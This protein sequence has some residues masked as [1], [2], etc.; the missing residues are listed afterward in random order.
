LRKTSLERLLAR[1]PEGIFVNPFERGKIGSELYRAAC[2]MGL[3][4]IVSKR[5]DRSYQGGRSKHWV[6]IKNRQD[7]AMD[8]EF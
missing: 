1:R 2:W 4:G 6:K 7:Q 3:E 8:R 5:R